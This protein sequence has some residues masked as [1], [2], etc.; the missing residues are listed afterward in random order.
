MPAETS[1]YESDYYA[2]AMDQAAALRRAAARR[3]NDVGLD[4]ENLAEEIED[5]GKSQAQRVY[6]TLMRI[7]EHLAT[8]EH[9]PAAEPRAGWR[10]SVIE[11]RL[12]LERALKQ[13]PSLKT[14]LPE[15]AADAWE[16]AR[17]LAADSLAGDGIP[18]AVLP[19]AC[20]CPLD[21]LRAQGWYPANRHGLS[22]PA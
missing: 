22:D 13:S 4:Y 11:H 17:V 5:L 9:S 14:R 15:L 10:R 8:L 19:E 2:W 20:P 3:L 21:R 16:D 6:S 1:I 18:A 7:A 12:R